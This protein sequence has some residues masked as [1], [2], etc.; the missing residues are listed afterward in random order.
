VATPRSSGPTKS[1][2]FGKSKSNVGK[3]NK[4]Q[5]PI[6]EAQPEKP[7]VGRGRPFTKPGAPRQGMKGMGG[8][9]NKGKPGQ[10]GFGGDKSK[11]Y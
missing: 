9:A 4:P 3:A 10:S 8:I 2:P 7:S 1:P 6:P 11:G 5:P